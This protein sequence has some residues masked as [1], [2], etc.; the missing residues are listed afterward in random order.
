MLEGP[1]DILPQ[2]KKSTQGTEHNKIETLE[3]GTVQKSPIS[4]EEW[5]EIQVRS[6]LDAL[7][8]RKKPADYTVSYKQDVKTEDVF[9]QVKKISEFLQKCLILK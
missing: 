6:D 5:E 9:L 7:E 4:I 2:K 8:I 3:R 1:G